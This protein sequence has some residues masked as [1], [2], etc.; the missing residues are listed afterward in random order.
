MLL[1][2]WIISA[3]F[4]FSMAVA[5]GAVFAKEDS[6]T[7]GHDWSYAGAHGP[8]HWGALQAEYT[9]CIS[10]KHQSPIDIRGAVPTD[11]DPI[12]FAYNASPL[13]MVDNG[14]TIQV[15][16][17]AGSSMTVGGQQ[18]ELVQFHFHKPSEEKINGK[19]FAMV[20]HFV[21]KNPEGKFA[22]VAVL[23]K[24]WK[25]NPFVQTLW[26]NL[27]KEKDKE[28]TIERVSIDATTFLPRNHAYY[29]FP[30]SLTSPPCSE[31]VTWFVLNTP[32]EVSGAQ[33][34]RFGKIY[35][36]YGRGV[37]DRHCPHYASKSSV[38]ANS[39]NTFFP[40]ASAYLV[41][42]LTLGL[43]SA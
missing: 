25:Q 9:T 42:V 29:T 20:A 2:R 28:H 5:P 18:Y 12:K 37:R 19:A 8:K 26:S 22:V 35:S 3:M 43:P 30:G 13:N 40:T 27:P 7:P 24:N 14:H 15:N 38:S 21:H 1:S 31:G 32:V 36:K 10:G 34:A 16:Y 41:S 4:V 23:M 6:V 11:L 33:V 17:G 39:T